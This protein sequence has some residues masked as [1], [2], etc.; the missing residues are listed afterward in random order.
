MGKI[1]KNL[2]F[3][4]NLKKIK[5]MF[6]VPSLT[7]FKVLCFKAKIMKKVNSGGR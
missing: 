6:I 5:V 1:N 2:R 7:N 3:Y 4:K